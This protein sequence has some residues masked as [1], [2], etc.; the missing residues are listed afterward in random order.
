LNRTKIEWTDFTWNPV[1]GCLHGCEYCYGR[2]IAKRFPKLFPNGYEPTF[3]PERLKEPY[4][5]SKRFRSKNPN[6]PRG[7]A[8]IFT[9]SM[10]DLFGDWVSIEWIYPILNVVRNNPHHIFQFLTKN[11]YRLKDFPFTQNSWVGA[12]V[13]WVTTESL[14]RVRNALSKVRNP[15]IRFISIEPFLHLDFLVEPEDFEGFDWIIIGA[16]TNPYRPPKPEWV[17]RIL[18][19]AEKL[20]I[21]VFLKDNLRWPEKIQEF[22]DLCGKRRADE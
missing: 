14:T 6:L 9:V 13:D 20:D 11:P 5:V 2:K 21:P 17:E 16:Q 10:G 12:T 3:H 7:S 19:A 1:T 8:M 15:S 18:I 4:Q 22:P